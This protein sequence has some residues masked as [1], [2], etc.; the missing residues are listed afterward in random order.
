MGTM[1]SSACSCV[2]QIEDQRRAILFA[3]SNAARRTIE[4][5]RPST[6]CRHLLDE[7]VSASERR[8]AGIDLDRAGPGDGVGQQA[9]AQPR[10]PKRDLADQ[11]EDADTRLARRDEHMR[12]RRIGRDRLGDQRDRRR[13]GGCGA[14]DRVRLA[15]I[16]RDFDQQVA[17]DAVR[18]DEHLAVRQH[19]CS[20]RNLVGISGAARQ[21]R[22][23]VLAVATQLVRRRLPSP[24]ARP[25]SSEAAEQ[26]AHP[27]SVYGDG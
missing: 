25:C 8:R 27:N 11:V 21:R 13:L 16:G 20:Q 22:G 14:Q 23:G 9:L 17:V 4:Q 18:V 10:A 6:P 7:M 1:L 19:K 26:G 3:L 15:E 5:P 12:D 2:P 24:A